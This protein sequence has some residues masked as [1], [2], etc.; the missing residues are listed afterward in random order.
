MDS[1]II[2]HVY[3]FHKDCKSTIIANLNK[4]QNFVILSQTLYIEVMD[5]QT[6]IAYVI[7]SGIDIK[8]YGY[9][10]L[11]NMGE[12]LQKMVNGSQKLGVITKCKQFYAEYA[13][14]LTQSFMSESNIPVW[15][16]NY[17]SYSLILS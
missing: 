10:I 11:Q 2:Y 5:P 13:V 3:N 15:L 4:M 9:D 6:F 1:E 8:M 17:I 7:R 16:N 14:L 12:L